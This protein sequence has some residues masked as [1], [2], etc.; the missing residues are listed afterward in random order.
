[1]NGLPEDDYLW[2]GS[3]TPDPFVVS[4]EST[5]SALRSPPDLELGEPDAFQAQPAPT[6]TMPW[7]EIAIASM[8]A[9]AV[10]AALWI[11]RAPPRTQEQPVQ[12]PVANPDGESPSETGTEAPD[13]GRRVSPDLK[14]PFAPRGESD[15]SADVAPADS[16]PS[17][18]AGSETGEAGGSELVDPFGGS[19]PKDKADADVGTELQDPWAD[20][21]K[22]KK[23]PPKKKKKRVKKNKGGISPD[24]K[25]PF[26]KKNVGENG[27]DLEDPFKD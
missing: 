3:G 1:M 12:D 9:A 17:D 10:L 21:A 14:D 11:W 27:P 24:L 23:A 26:S 7:K 6:R 15:S 16:Q 2:D 5:L 8:A 20:G 19:P 25:D 13:Q 4:L 22:K 18:A